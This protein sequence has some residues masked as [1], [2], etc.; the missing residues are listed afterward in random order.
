MDIPVYLSEIRALHASGKSTE[1][2]FRPALAKL[3]SSIDAAIS[4]INEPKHI[5]DVG[6]PDFVFQRDNVAIGWCEAKDIGKDIR[7]FAANDYSKAQKERYKKGLPNLIYTN[8]LDFEFIR[9]GEVVDFVTIAD[10][11]PTMP[12]R[13]AAFATLQARLSEFASVTPLSVTSSR[14]LA[15][16]MAGKAALIKDIMGNAL[17]ADLKAKE[18]T[19]SA[20]DLI[21]QYEAFRANLI[22]DITV[23]DFADIYAETIAYGLFAAR[24]HDASP[25]SFS[26]AE[27]L[28]LLPK[29][30]PFLRE[31]F[32]YIAG[33][34]LDERLRR[35][36][37][38]L[39]AVFRAT[40][41][42]EVLKHFGK[43]TA[44]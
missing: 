26:R 9:D 1:H 6:A 14:Q 3:F 29:S 8:G 33:P 4:V 38:D 19:G 21:G 20:T 13:P 42:G 18:A 35:V 16:L 28:E 24:L 10:L 34:N 2:S 11:I 44:R 36:I 7:K 40:N 23:A 12:A 41:M 15:K 25:Q 32:I 5:T 27:A 30:N 17:L 39:C 43:V 37:D 31:L 22:G